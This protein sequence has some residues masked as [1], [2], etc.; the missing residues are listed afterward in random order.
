[1]AI[2][3]KIPLFGGIFFCAEAEFISAPFARY[4]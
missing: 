3:L 2:N 4:P 1:M